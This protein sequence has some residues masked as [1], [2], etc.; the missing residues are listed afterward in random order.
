M[1]T[2]DG[3]EKLAAKLDSNPEL[4][5]V[6]GNSLVTEVDYQGNWRQDVMTYS[7]T[8]FNQ[9]LVYLDTCYLTY[10]GGLYRKNIHKKNLVSTMK[11]SEVQE[12]QN[13]KTECYPISKPV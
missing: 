7:R 5:W 6:I 12:I 10:V 13:L 4:D 2:C 9:N 3:L 8:K 11:H 1:I